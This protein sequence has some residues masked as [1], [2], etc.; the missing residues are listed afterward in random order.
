M[1]LLVILTFLFAPAYLFSQKNA[2]VSFEKW[3]SLTGVFSPIISPDGKT[4]VYSVG[5]TDWSNNS[6]DSELWM[7]REGLSPLQLTRTSKGT[8]FGARFTPD[9]RFVSFLAERGDKTQLYIISVY[10]G[11]ALQATKDEDGINNYEWNP[12][13]SRIAYTK[14]EP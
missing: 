6:Y 8:S 1:K 14:S 12:D 9:S 7:V 4:I 3:I 13:G 5:T 11:E 10:G 2:S